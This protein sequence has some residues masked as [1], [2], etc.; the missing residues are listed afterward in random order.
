MLRAM[1]VS[2]KDTSPQAQSLPAS[3]P[4]HGSGNG[5]HD[6]ADALEAVSPLDTTDGLDAELS[7]V[8]SDLG[9]EYIAYRAMS[10]SA[11]VSLGLGLL[12]ALA[13]FDWTLAIIPILGIILGIRGLL[14]VKRY[15]DQLT[16]A[17]LA[18]AGIAL[19]LAGWVIGWGWLG[20]V[21]ATEVPEGYQR[22][23]YRQLQFPYD[24][25]TGRLEIPESVRQ[26]DGEKIF[27]K[28]YVYPTYSSKRFI[29]CRDNG[30]CCFGG[31]PKLT[32]M[33]YVTLRDP[34][35]LR[36]DPKLKKLAGVLRVAPVQPGHIDQ[37]LASQIGPVI[38]QLEADHLE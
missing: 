24:L 7:D 8:P 14:A 38:Y 10:G 11:V 34:L 4:V 9:E 15:P 13:I 22:I 36:Y 6:P 19:S 37:E 35:R 25:S 16:G 31:Q 23:S 27:I 17:G 1:P 18:T 12:S 5:P 28:G 33:I 3:S 20:Y 30:D 2:P 29:L 32:D 21:Y 26:L